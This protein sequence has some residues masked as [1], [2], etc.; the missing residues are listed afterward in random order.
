[1]VK[2]LFGVCALLLA[3]A[4]QASEKI[5]AV[6]AHK[7]LSDIIEEIVAQDSGKLYFSEVDTP[8]IEISL[9]PEGGWVV[10]WT[11]RKGGQ[12]TKMNNPQMA[13]ST[14]YKITEDDG[15]D[16]EIFIRSGKFNGYKGPRTNMLRVT[17]DPETSI[18]YYL[19]TKGGKND[20]MDEIINSILFKHLP[21]MKAGFWDSKKYFSSIKITYR[22]WIWIIHGDGYGEMF[23]GSGAGGVLARFQLS[24]AGLKESLLKHSK[25]DESVIV[26]GGLVVR[27]SPEKWA[28]ISIA[29]N[30]KEVFFGTLENDN[31]AIDKIFIM[32]LEKIEPVD[33]KLFYGLLKN[34][35]PI[36]KV[37]KNL[38]EK[39]NDY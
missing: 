15:I 5:A 28:N 23:F 29:E 39:L 10:R 9:Q 13:L 4:L 35:L 24:Y 38:E 20:E 27:A 1:M 17:D 25:Q 2:S 16:F 37:P 7:M 18:G 11:H 26:E 8:R 30:G 31:L 21:E 32:V 3:A 33:S 19:R 14:Y 12:W 34:N 6:Y 22:K 36:S